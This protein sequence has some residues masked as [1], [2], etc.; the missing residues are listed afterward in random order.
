[1]DFYKK[2]MDQKKPPN[3]TYHKV[4]MSKAQLK[5]NEDRTDHITG[6]PSDRNS[7]ERRLE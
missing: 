1:M 5:K 6:I 3:R 4:P 2:W 7:K